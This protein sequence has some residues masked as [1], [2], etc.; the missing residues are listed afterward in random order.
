MGNIIQLIGDINAA[1]AIKADDFARTGAA[2]ATGEIYSATAGIH[3]FHNNLLSRRIIISA[4]LVFIAALASVPHRSALYNLVLIAQGYHGVTELPAAIIGIFNSRNCTLRCAVNGQIIIA[5]AALNN[6]VHVDIRGV[7]I[8]GATG[9]IA[10]TAT[11]AI[12]RQFFGDTNRA[13]SLTIEQLVKVVAIEIL[14]TAANAHNAVGVAL[15]DAALGC[16]EHHVGT[17]DGHIISGILPLNQDIIFRTGNSNLTIS[18]DNIALNLDI[19]QRLA[20]QIVD[21]NRTAGATG[22]RNSA[23]VDNLLQLVVAQNGH[24]AIFALGGHCLGKASLDGAGIA[25]VQ[26]INLRIQRSGYFRI[27]ST[28]RSHSGAIINQHAAG[29]VHNDIVHL[30]QQIGVIGDIDG[31]SALGLHLAAATKIAGSNIHITA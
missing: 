31:R 18:I 24:S 1:G 11:A 17:G 3:V 22:V 26:S 30:Q 27:R 9:N 8:H 5:I 4:Q 12:L 7:N 16:G 15:G 14:H 19:S 29:L 6:A 13:H 20:F 10:A 23:I 28:C 25:L 2:D 21:G